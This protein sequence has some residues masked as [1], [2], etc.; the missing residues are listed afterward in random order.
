MAK[1]GFIHRELDEF[2]VPDLLVSLLAEC[3]CVADLCIFKRVGVGVGLKD[4][5]R[6]RT[7]VSC[8]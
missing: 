6:V 3:E 4:G 5:G 7:G 2:F 1:E 8:E